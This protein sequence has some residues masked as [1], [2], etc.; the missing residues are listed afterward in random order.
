[1]L[2]SLQLEN[3]KAFGQRTVLPLAP[4]T[5]LFGQNSSGKSSVLQSLNLLKQTRES[6]DVEALLL[7]RTENGFADLGSF[8]ELLFDHEL[9]R[10]LSIRLDVAITKNMREPGIVPRLLRR[11]STV[12][13]EFSFS[14]RKPEDEITL[15]GFKLCSEDPNKFVASFEN[16]EIPRELRRYAGAPYRSERRRSLTTLRAARCTAVN[17]DPT[18]WLPAYEWSLREKGR[19]LAM[20]REAQSNLQSDREPPYMRGLFDTTKNKRLTNEDA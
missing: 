3:F 18:F 15:E 16:C 13:L 2:R 19:L 17:D 7:P 6:R 5:L 10:S 11:A 1:M 8:Q 20:L 12:G 14:R 4:I 9:N